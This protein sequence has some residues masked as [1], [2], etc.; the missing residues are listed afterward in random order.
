MNLP[1]KPSATNSPARFQLPSVAF[2]GR[3]MSEYLQM[4]A[5][6]KGQLRGL[7]ILDVAS[8]PGSFV[9]EALAVGLDVT[10]CDPLY[11]GDPEQITA[12]GKADI[13]ACREQIRRN[14]EVLLYADIEA[15]YRDK[16]TALE[17]FAADFTTRRNEGR[18]VAG[19]LPSL[20]FADT[21]FD[22]V[23]TA[24][25]LMVYAPLEDGG[26][27]QGT[28]FGLAFHLRAVEEL[29]RVTK[30][31][32]RISG[33]HTWKH[34]PERHPYCHPMMNRLEEL[35]MRAEL[36]QSHYDDGCSITNPACN[37]VL[38]ARR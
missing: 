7:A 12:Q 16:Y 14:P 17:R 28:D 5:L 20:P 21:S 38:V 30:S 29:A 35:G 22:L 15:F 10:G 8:G 13:D 33:M 3:T 24:N 31:E 34:P 4:L 37:Q 25:L 32:L 11:D 26:M 9:A 2:F 18:Y 27:S 36:V 1:M 23:L 19:A 6:D